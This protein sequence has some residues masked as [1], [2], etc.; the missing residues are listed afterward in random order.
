[1]TAFRHLLATVSVFVFGT[2]AQTYIQTESAQAQAPISEVELACERALNAGSIEEIEY[3]LSR[4]PQS[5][6]GNET[7]CYAMAMEALDEFG[8]TTQNELSN[9]N[10]KNRGPYGD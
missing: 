8:P 1:M 9:N 6:Y 3:F 2:A 7:T 10:D 5:V 4:Y